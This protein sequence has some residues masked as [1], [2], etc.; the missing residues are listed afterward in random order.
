MHVLCFLFSLNVCCSPPPLAPLHNAGSL[1]HH[2][3]CDT[4]SR[5]DDCACFALFPFRLKARR[6]SRSPPT[7][8]PAAPRET[9]ARLAAH[10]RSHPA[11]RPPFLGCH[12]DAPARCAARRPPPLAVRNEQRVRSP[13]RRV[14]HADP[15]PRL[16]FFA[17]DA[18]RSHLAIYKFRVNMITSVIFRGASR[19]TEPRERAAARPPFF[20]PTAPLF[21]LSRA[22]QALAS[23]WRVAF[24]PWRLAA[25]CR[26]R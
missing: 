19:L 9:R 16:R 21:S 14:A 20:S 18:R 22:P 7:P 1:R 3:S 8:P 26:R 2:D 25:S 24:P 6:A 12:Q 10:S 11:A 5:H 23:S 4:A 13:P 15:P 17:R